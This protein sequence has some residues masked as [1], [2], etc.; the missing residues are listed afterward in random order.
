MTNNTTSA[1][2]EFLERALE[3]DHVRI[4]VASPAFAV[5]RKNVRRLV[6]I[7]SEDQASIASAEGMQYSLLQWLSVPMP[8]TEFDLSPILALGTPGTV[9]LRWGEDAHRCLVEAS[10][11]FAEIRTSENPLRVAVQD[12]LLDAAASRNSLQIYCHR[13][14]RAHFES[15]EHWK[16]IIDLATVDFLGS[17]RDYRASAPFDTL[18]KVGPL[19]TRGFSSIPGAVINAP[20]FRKLIQVAWLGTP[21][22]PGFGVDPIIERWE[23]HEEGTVAREAPD[24]ESRSIVAYTRQT[25]VVGDT[26]MRSLTDFTDVDDFSAERG[27]RS[28]RAGTLRKAMLLYLGN[29]L[30]CLQAPHAD[31]ICLHREGAKVTASRTEPTNID[32]RITHLVDPALQQVDL[33]TVQSSHGRFAPQWKARLREEYYRNPIAL[34]DGL[35]RGGIAL[36]NLDSRVR[37]W[38]ELSGSV[39]HSPQQRRHF[40]ILIHVLGIEGD[41]ISYPRG[42]RLSWSAAAWTEIAHSRGVAIQHGAERNE[43]ITE[44]L[45]ILLNNEGTTFAD[46]VK[47]GESFTWQIPSGRSLTGHIR[48]HAIHEV[49]DGY[50]CPEQILKT[51]EPIEKL[52]PWRE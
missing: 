22:Q 27:S 40:E 21:D 37:E 41:P 18:L 47:P 6:E 13:T 8:F 3:L 16:D 10:L 19:R 2:Y 36:V 51:I 9:A 7:V 12:A 46:Q 5:L 48:L 44:E 14:A 31:I 43:I 25:L 26:R 33:G 29:G 11:A 24:H 49:E 30:G 23:C 38:L 28:A 4:D 45:E 42:R 50:R 20:R 32:D 1:V 15:L 34:L 35:R 17:P 39:I 52:L